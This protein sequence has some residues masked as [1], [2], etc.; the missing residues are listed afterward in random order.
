M[1]SLRAH[2]GGTRGAA[3]DLLWVDRE[4]RLLRRELPTRGLHVRVSTPPFPSRRLTAIVEAWLR[5]RRAT[6]LERSLIMQRW[7][8]GIDEPHALLIGVGPVS[9]KAVA[10]AWLDHEDPLGHE[11]VKRVEADSIA[12]G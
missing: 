3:I 8:L 10:H 2:I 11:V 5:T 6:C 7:L 1:T 9:G 4:L 12:A